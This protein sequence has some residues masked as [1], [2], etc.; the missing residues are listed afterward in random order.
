MSV[1]SLLV[2]VAVEEVVVELEVGEEGVVLGRIRL[3]VGRMSC[4]WG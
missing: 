2:G 1:S 3:L 4:R